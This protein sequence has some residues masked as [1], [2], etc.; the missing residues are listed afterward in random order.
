MI[1]VNYSNEKNKLTNL[2]R[3]VV[4]RRRHMLHGDLYLVICVHGV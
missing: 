2:L 1:S 4:S 3:G